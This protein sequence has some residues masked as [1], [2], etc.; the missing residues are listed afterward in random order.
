MI[1]QQFRKLFFIALLLNAVQVQAQP[2]QISASDGVDTEPARAETSEKPETPQEEGIEVIEV[3]A[4]LPVGVYRQKLFTKKEAYYKAFNLLIEDEEFHIVCER[5]YGLKSVGEARLKCEPKFAQ[6]LRSELHSE[7][8]A[9]HPNNALEMSFISQ[10]EYRRRFEKKRKE[11]HAMMR[12]VLLESPPLM[13]R[14]QELNSAQQIYQ[15][16]HVERFGKLSKYAWVS[17]PDEGG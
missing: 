15:A 13:L 17:E 6:T 11:L 7:R 8:S 9:N 10:T 1:E 12:K 4:W 5:I 16:S 2:Q 14:L 3:R